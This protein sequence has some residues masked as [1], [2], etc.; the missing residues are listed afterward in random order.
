VNRLVPTTNGPPVPQSAFAAA[1]D[2]ITAR[3]AQSVNK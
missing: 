1:Y 3:V 2:S